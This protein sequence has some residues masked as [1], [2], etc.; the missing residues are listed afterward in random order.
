M[1]K[2]Y[3]RRM[4]AAETAAY[5]NFEEQTLAAWRS[6]RKGPPFIKLGKAVRYSQR[7]VDEWLKKNTVQ[8]G[9]AAT[10]DELTA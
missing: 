7:A 5:I 9:A 6:A 2:N 8:C 4:T 10:V 1:D 3:D